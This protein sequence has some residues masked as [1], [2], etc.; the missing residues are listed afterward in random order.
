MRCAVEQDEVAE[1]A[2]AAKIGEGRTA[3]AVID[4]DADAR[5]RARQVAQ[6]F[7]GIV[8][9]AKLELVL[10]DDRD[11]RGGDQVGV[12]DQGA[13]DDDRRSFFGG[14]AAGCPVGAG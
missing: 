12:P 1:I 13:G 14:C 4:R 5:D 11:R 2:E 10:A 9:L 3:I 7:L 8:G 6:H